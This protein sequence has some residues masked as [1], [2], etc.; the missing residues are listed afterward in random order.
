MNKKYTKIEKPWG[1]EQIIEL[2]NNYCLKK[3]FMKKGCRCSLQ[4]HEKK[5][6]TIYVLKGTLHIE[7]NDNNMQLKKDETTT[8]NVGEIHRMS[9]IDD[10][11]L[12]LESSS[13][14]LEDVKRIEDDFGR[15]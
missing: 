14:E 15:N 6:E 5:T 4:Y 13:P 3:L 8:I 12:Y 9:A 11:V 2:N 7:L 1:Y 10:D